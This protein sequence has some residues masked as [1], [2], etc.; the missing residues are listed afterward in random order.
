MIKKEICSQPRQLKSSMATAQE[1]MN[2]ASTSKMRKKTGHQIKRHRVPEAGPAGGDHPAFIRPGFFRVGS[3][4]PQP[5]GQKQQHGQQP[6]HDGH[7][8]GKAQERRDP[9]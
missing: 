1:K 2:A 6:R 9:G 8:E 4:L 7:I 5:A 3:F